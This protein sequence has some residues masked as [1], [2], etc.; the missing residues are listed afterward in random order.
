M[1]R[2]CVDLGVLTAIG[3]SLPKIGS[4][5]ADLESAVQNRAREGVGKADAA[6]NRLEKRAAAAESEAETL[7]AEMKAVQARIDELEC[8][9]RQ[10]E[11]DDE[12]G[13]AECSAE[14]QRCRSRMDSLRSRAAG[15]EEEAERSR[16]KMR[17]LDGAC[18]RVSEECTRVTEAQ[19]R[20]AEEVE[21]NAGH[22][23]KIEASVRAYL[24]VSPA[25]Y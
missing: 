13:A 25:R 22:L 18:S 14:I 15:K 24:A 2:Y 9:R 20:H 7:R 5:S 16:E 12:E 23:K 1:A 6:K 17:A 11:E 10:Q 8:S 4:A 21:K 3:A 19:R